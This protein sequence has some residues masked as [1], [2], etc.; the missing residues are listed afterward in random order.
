MPKE[1]CD[2]EWEIRK[3]HLENVYHKFSLPWTQTPGEAHR[4]QAK[5]PKCLLPL[6]FTLLTK[7]T[8]HRWFSF[9][10]AHMTDPL[11]K[12][13]ECWK[14]SSLNRRRS[15]CSFFG[16]W[17]LISPS[18]QGSPQMYETPPPQ[19]HRPPPPPASAPKEVALGRFSEH[20]WRKSP[21][22]ENPQTV[23]LVC[24]FAGA[25]RPEGTHTRQHSFL[26]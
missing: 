7:E 9:S 17:H 26:Q 25:G 4:F 5:I 2:R 3:V 24:H 23:V 6:K 1:N 16:L 8:R 18:S 21:A 14:G 22:L 20:V 13:S 10:M 15:F 11:G 19:G 12:Q